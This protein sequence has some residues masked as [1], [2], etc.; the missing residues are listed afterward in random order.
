[1]VKVGNLTGLTEHNNLWHP[2]V[3]QQLTTVAEQI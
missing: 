2:F 3:C 1:M